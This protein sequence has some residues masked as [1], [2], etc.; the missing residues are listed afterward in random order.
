MRF[1]KLASITALLFCLTSCSSPPVTGPEAG[2]TLI[3]DSAKA[4]G[5]WANIDAVKS[6]EILTGGGD[7]EPMQSLEP[8]GE[9]R[10]VDIF[11]QTI[12]IDLEKNRLRFTHDAKRTYPQP[13]PVKFV[14]VIDGNVGMLLSTSADGK[15]QTERLH[16]SRLATRLR[17][18]NRLPIRV[19]KVAKAAPDLTRTPDVVVDKKTYHVVKYTDSGL[20]AQLQIDGFTNLPSRVIYTEDDP[21][22]GDTLNEVTF[23]D[24]KDRDGVRLPDTI[25]TALNGQKIREEHVRTLINNTKYDESS[26]A[27]PDDVRSTPEVG[28]RIVSQWPLRRIVMGVG[29][30]DFG[31]DQNVQLDQLAPGVY[32]VTG[33]SHNSLA[34]EMKDHILV[35]E[36]PLF[37][38]RSAAVIQA[39]G[40]KIPGKE[41]KEVVLTHYH[42]DHSGGMRAYLA[43]GATIYVHESIVPFAKD[44][45]ARPH[46]VRPDLFAKAGGNKGTVEGVGE[47]GKTLTDGDRTVQIFTVPN[48]HAA[49]MLAVYL[50]K[51]KLAFVSDLYTPGAPVQPGDPN[52]SAFLSAVTRANFSID[53]VAG[54]HG[55]VGP[56]KD[57]QKVGAVSKMGS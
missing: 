17:D 40:E 49:G 47:A 14:E 42:N 4:M 33:S 24:W 44:V 31:R 10:Q 48:A 15:T 23:G 29:Y 51:E 7:W 56:F 54:G 11:G 13:G 35:V 53:R 6:Q 21:L 12:L 37:D 27:I 20:A 30:Q 34:I 2:K 18:I 3:E 8:K 36:T 39:L 1:A 38:E 19:L 46:T 57:L 55:G 22:Y 5:G 9:P 25:T 41:I 32:H 26:F 52:A 43:Q 50:P 45:L 16:A 28:Q